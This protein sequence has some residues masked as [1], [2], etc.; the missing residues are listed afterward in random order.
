MFMGPLEATKPWKTEGLNGSH[1]FLKRAWRLLISEEGDPTQTQ[2]E[3]SEGF[4]KLLHKTIKK[5]TEDVENLRFN[6]AIAAMMELVNAAYKEPQI[7]CEAA[8]AF[9]KLLSPFAPHLTEELWS[10][11]GATKT[12]AYE[13]WPEYDENMVQEEQ[14]TLSVQV[15]GKLRG[16]IEVGVDSAREDVLTKARSLETVQRHLEGKDVKKEIF[17]PGKIVNFVAK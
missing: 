11:Y 9:I 8:K 17:V 16:T 13:S 14:V 3:C 10:R 7:G 4:R 12:L 1:R 2:N 5:V 15:N 6:T